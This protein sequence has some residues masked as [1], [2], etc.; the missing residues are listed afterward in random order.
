MCIR[1]R[2]YFFLKYI[3]KHLMLYSSTM[4]IQFLLHDTC[5]LCGLE[6]CC[7]CDRMPFW[8][9]SENFFLCALEKVKNYTVIQ[10]N[11]LKKIGKN[12][13]LLRYSG[14]NTRGFSFNKT[15]TYVVA[16]IKSN[17][18]VSLLYY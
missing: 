13:V 7:F 10:Y 3:S 17:Y 14:S 11:K 12:F 8:H 6:Q 4:K 15:C 2:Y 9:V 18:I 16:A 1:D 5:L